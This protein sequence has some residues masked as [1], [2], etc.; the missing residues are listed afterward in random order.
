M[1]GCGKNWACAADLTVAESSCIRY[2][3]TDLYRKCVIVTL[4]QQSRCDRKISSYQEALKDIWKTVWYE[5]QFQPWNPD[6]GSQILTVWVCLCQ[7][8]LQGAPSFQHAGKSNFLLPSP[9]AKLKM[10]AFLSVSVGS[11]QLPPCKRVNSQKATATL[12]LPA[13]LNA[14]PP[15]ARMICRCR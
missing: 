7:A 10:A 9:S 8:C 1:C 3:Y 13:L 12:N 5:S 14:A 2:L 15:D 11:S 6:S 4:Y